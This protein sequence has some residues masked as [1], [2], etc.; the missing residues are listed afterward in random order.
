MNKRSPPP[1][2]W[3]ASRNSN[4]VTND[5]FSS[6]SSQ[7]MLSDQEAQIVRLLMSGLSISE[8]AKR[9]GA[10]ESLVRDHIKSILE[11]AK[12]ALDSGHKQS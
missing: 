7:R 1:R 12:N 2:R 4:N 3:S 9:L 11:K 5:I 8:I 10:D 6:E